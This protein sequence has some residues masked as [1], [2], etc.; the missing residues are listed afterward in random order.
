MPAWRFIVPVVVTL[1]VSPSFGGQGGARHTSATKASSRIR[2]SINQWLTDPLFTYAHHGQASRAC[3]RP[4]KSASLKQR[5]EG[6]PYSLLA[7]ERSP[8]VR[9]AGYKPSIFKKR[10]RRLLQNH[11]A[12]NP[13]THT[14]ST[15]PRGLN[16]PAGS[17]QPDPRIRTHTKQTTTTLPKQSRIHRH[18]GYQWKDN[19]V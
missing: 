9:G 12:L 11:T 3:E 6:T 10:A 19:E 8:P 13:A 7:S 15:R 1:D 4:T 16:R 17:F 5:A 18:I 14:C 2:G